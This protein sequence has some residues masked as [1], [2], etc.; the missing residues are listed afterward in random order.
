MAVFTKRQAGYMS[1]KLHQVVHIC[2]V[3]ASSTRVRFQRKGLIYSLARKE[4]QLNRLNV[5]L[6]SA[7]ANIGMF[8]RSQKS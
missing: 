4:R 5:K 7:R 6:S 8:I 3:A 2:I 1:V